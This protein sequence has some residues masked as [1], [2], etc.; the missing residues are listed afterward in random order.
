MWDEKRIDFWVLPAPTLISVE[1]KGHTCISKEATEYLGACRLTVHHLSSIEEAVV[2]ALVAEVL[3]EGKHV[4]VALQSFHWT[5]ANH[6]AETCLDQ[7]EH[8][9]SQSIRP[10]PGPK[11]RT[12]GQAL[13][14]VECGNTVS[15]QIDLRTVDLAFAVLICMKVAPYLARIKEFGMIVAG[16]ARQTVQ[17]RLRV[18]AYAM[19]TIVGLTTSD[20]N[21]LVFGDARLTH[22]IDCLSISD[23]LRPGTEKQCQST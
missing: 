11:S 14:D 20:R 6:S 12:S 4:G 22:H 9:V 7:T 15:S 8:V 13:G 10:D 23:N 18:H 3:P 19:T 16:P 5:I 17:R 1:N 21:E 2:V